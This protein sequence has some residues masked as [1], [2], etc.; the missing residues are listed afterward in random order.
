MYRVLVA[1]DEPP[2]L[3]SICS[4]IERRSKEYKVVATAENGQEAMREIRRIMPELVICDIKMPLLSGVELAAVVREEF[5]EITFIIVSGYQDFEYAQSAIRSGVVDYILKPV[6]PSVLLKSLESAGARIREIQYAERNRILRALGSGEA[7][8]M[9][10]VK[11]Y[12]PY[13][14]FYGAIL[15]VNGLPRRFSVDKSRQIYSD[16]Q[17]QY[18]VFGRDEMESLFL[19]PQDLL[20]ENIFIKY[21]EQVEGRQKKEN[22]Y[23]LIY[24]SKPFPAEKLQEKIRQMYQRLDQCSSVGMTQRLN[25]E[26]LTRVQREKASASLLRKTEE[27]TLSSIEAI[28]RTGKLEQIEAEIRKKYEILEQYHPPQL[29]LENFTREVFAVMRRHGL[30]RLSMAEGEYFLNDAFF[31]ATSVRMLTD[32]LMDAFLSCEKDRT[33]S[34]KVDSQEYFD[35]IDGFLRMNLGKPVSLMDLCH[36]FGISQTYM[37]RLFRKYSGNSFSQYLTELRMNRAKE[38]FCEKPDSFIKD[39]AV[40]V[41]YEDQFYFSRIFRSYT[42]KSPSEYLKEVADSRQP[43]AP[44]NIS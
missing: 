6:V 13:R 7:V 39:I 36:Q 5:P 38:L 8:D 42:G 16:I 20:S 18:V 10:V 11:R 29:W 27:Q 43:V 21:L 41:G 40:M 22:Y 44:V 1:D 33:R 17:E 25:L 4:I 9:E 2:A 3:K 34:N 15:R 23:T 14:S 32:S 31:G 12:L 19:I 37:S 30:C 28:V 24:D 35:S 26:D